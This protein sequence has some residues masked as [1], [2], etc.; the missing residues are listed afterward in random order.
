M[1]IAMSVIHSDGNCVLH[2]YCIPLAR[3]R[4]E[5]P[6]SLHD[7][8]ANACCVVGSALHL[9]IDVLYPPDWSAFEGTTKASHPQESQSPRQ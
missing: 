6:R 3:G 8:F 1:L 7:L 5:T 2:T 4:R 9:H